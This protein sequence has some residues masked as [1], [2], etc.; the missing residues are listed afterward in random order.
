MKRKVIYTTVLICCSSLMASPNRN[1]TSCD[2]LT[3]KCKSI[4]QPVVNDNAALAAGI[5]EKA[6]AATGYLPGYSI[7]FIN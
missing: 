3:A 7:L 2:A 1:N 4:A 5:A 6:A